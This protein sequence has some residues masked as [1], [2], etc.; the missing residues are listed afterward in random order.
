MF[1]RFTFGLLALSALSTPAF[2]A[3]PYTLSPQLDLIGL[4]PAIQAAAH[5]GA[6]TGIL[7]ADIDTG[8]IPQWDGFKGTYNTAIARTANNINTKLSA[9]CL[10]GRCTTFGKDP[11][12]TDG[13][14]LSDG[15]GGGNNL[16][17]YDKDGHGTFTTSE[18]VGGVQGAGL[19]SI[20]PAGKLI[21]VQVLGLNGGTFA[22]VAAG[23]KYAANSGAKFLNLSLGPHGGTPLQQE[24]S[25]EALAP[26]V[27]YAASKGC[28]IVFAGGNDS[29]NFAGGNNVRGFTNLALSHLL[30][31]GST[32]ASEN[33]SFF[34]NTPGGGHFISTTGAIVPYQNLW[35]M[36]DGEDIWGASIF[37]DPVN[38]YAYIQQDSGTSMSAP[39]V[40]GIAGLLAARWP[41]LIKKGTLATLIKTTATD[42][43]GAGID[44][45]Y[46][47]GF[48][49]AAA[50][51]SSVGLLSVPSSGGAPVLLVGGLS[52]S[53]ALGNLSSVSRVLSNASYYDSYD[54]DFPANLGAPIKT[55]ASSVPLSGATIRV[56]G[57]DGAGTRSFNQTSDGGWASFT[58]APQSGLPHPDTPTATPLAQD[59]ANTAPAPWMMA[60]QQANGTYVGAGQGPDAALS[61]N[62][63]RWGA[64]K[65][66]FANSR[67]SMGGA[68][69]GLTDTATYS[70]VGFDQGKDKHISLAIMSTAADDFTSSVGQQASAYGAAIG[71]TT[72]PSENWTLSWT[73]SYLGESDMLLGSPASG[74]LSLGQASTVSFGV[75]ANVNLGHGYNIGFDTVAATT[76]P[77]SN[78]QSVIAGT[79]RLVSA[80]ASAVITKENLTG[81]DDTLGVFAK[82][83]L[84][85]YGGSADVDVPRGEDAN[86]NP[87]I[88][89]ERVGLAPSGNETDIG[90]DYT[91]PLGFGVMSSVS[92]T[93]RD[94]ADNI[95]GA[96]D[97]AAMAHVNLRF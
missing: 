60:I 63:A 4:T 7:F 76:S 9:S 48:L 23:I 92:M 51:F 19:Y 90:F 40:T 68:L 24:Q 80:G 44:A 36:A 27:N 25:Y 49:N 96:R 50:A 16:F 75:G 43:G 89:K 13:G 2:A 47:R 52:T 53:P 20:A 57:Q 58:G 11:T 14:P 46:G 42:I 45:V 62:D 71:Y 26:A 81:R 8:V 86:G 83:P 32:D 91:R 6:G 35:V 17:P 77:S 94:D 55:K 64:G 61:F 59:P 67:D 70:S 93:Y 97:G 38:G 37:S 5:N 74:Y 1:K 15:P 88:Y 84:R 78:S 41:V 79:S 31:A 10:N 29:V 87:T 66:A 69:L 3:S 21:E 54:R 28:I 65:T 12:F 72:K 73:G 34:S 82:K 33:L 39:Q 22:D 18:I 30:L 95:A 56:T 85:V